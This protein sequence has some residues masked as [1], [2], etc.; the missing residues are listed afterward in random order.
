[1]P[2]VLFVVAIAA[3]S[4][5]TVA[6]AER[7]F[8]TSASFGYGSSPPAF[9][10]EVDSPRADCVPGRRVKVYRQ[11][12]GRDPL[13]GSDR[14]SST[15]QWVVERSIGDGRYYMR[16]VAREISAGTCRAYRSSTLSLP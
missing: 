2:S 14:T 3:L 4:A 15:G 8:P 7:E 16:V 9:L 11:R 13:L 5:A 10:G 12:S 1:M 6:L